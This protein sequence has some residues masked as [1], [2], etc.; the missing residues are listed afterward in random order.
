MA[1]AEPVFG[2]ASVDIVK[3]RKPC[4]HIAR[5]LPSIR[6]S[7]APFTFLVNIM[8]PSTPFLSL[9]VAWAADDLYGSG[10]PLDKASPTSPGLY[11]SSSSG[12]CL[13]KQLWMAIR[14]WSNATQT[15]TYTHSNPEQL[16]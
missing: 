6:L 2:L 1:A 10:T 15:H 7:T 4:F 11:Q 9:V 16:G 5:H 12:R 3:M 8:V 14:T 13:L